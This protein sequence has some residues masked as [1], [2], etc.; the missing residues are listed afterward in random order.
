[1]PALDEPLGAALEGDRAA[2]CGLT[3][4]PGSPK[5]ARDFTR[6]T[7][8]GWRLDSLYEDSSIVVSELVTNALRYGLR[9]G[10]PAWPFRLVLV[11]HQYHLVC[12]V[13]D[14]SDAAPIPLEP[15]YAAETG[16]GLHIIEAVSRAWGWTPLYYGRGKAVWAAF[17]LPTAAVCQI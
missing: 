15:D 4:E 1:M 7:L 9:C 10:E 3:P 16:R 6:T 5:V 13:T 11:R 8:A 2:A 17:S 14:P 12:M